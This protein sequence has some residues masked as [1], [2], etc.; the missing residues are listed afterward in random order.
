M[1][2]AAVMSMGVLGSAAALASVSIPFDGSL[3]AFDM[4]GVSQ[5]GPGNYGT[6]FEVADGFAVGPV[7]PQAGWTASGTNLPWA[8]VSTA[9]PATGS[10]HLRL[11]MDTTVPAGTTR[12]SLGPN[13]GA[14]PS[15]TSVSNANIAI[16]A[17][18]GGAYT[19]L[20][21]SPSEALITYRV[22]F[23]PNDGG[24][25]AGVP[26]IGVLDDP[27]GAGPL[28]LA[29]YLADTDA[30]AGIQGWAAGGYHAFRAEVTA[31]NILYYY[32]NV[33]MYTGAIYAGHRVEQIGALSSNT[34]VGDTGDIDDFS[35]AVPE[36]TSLA[37]LGLGALALRRRR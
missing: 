3:S 9:N 6:G 19:L 31:T 8:S 29:F 15:G 21:Q 5:R 18:G 7:E 2:F 16:S 27:D 36:P 23:F 25:G 14:L 34:Q 35:V 12:V 17:A 24:S 13:L 20:G 28:A 11:S 4:G 37:L 10:Q 26:V 32:D 1:K 22:Q 30:A 33:L